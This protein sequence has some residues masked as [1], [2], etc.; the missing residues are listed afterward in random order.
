MPSYNCPAPLDDLLSRMRAELRMCVSGHRS[1]CLLLVGCLHVHRCSSGPGCAWRCLL[2]RRQQEEPR[3]FALRIRTNLD[4]QGQGRRGHGG[5]EELREGPVSR[6]SLHCS[7]QALHA[8][9]SG[10]SHH[11]QAVAAPV[12]VSLPPVLAQRSASASHDRGTCA[13]RCW[14]AGCLSNS[15][16]I[17]ADGSCQVSTARDQ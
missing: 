8:A 3:L 5:V 2:T 4:V 7:R 17:R 13:Q 9:A 12:C 1:G 11:A 6:V 10:V 14:S 16:R 15:I